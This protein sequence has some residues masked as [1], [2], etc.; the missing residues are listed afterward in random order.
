MKGKRVIV[1]V[2]H[3]Q[4]HRRG[5]PCLTCDEMREERRQK[6][7]KVGSRILAWTVGLLFVAVIVSQCCISHV[8]VAQ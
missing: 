4:K 3:Y 8:E 2:L 7:M 5:C 1:P 6:F